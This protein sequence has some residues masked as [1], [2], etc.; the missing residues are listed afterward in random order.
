MPISILIFFEKLRA[1]LCK[2]AANFSAA[3]IYHFFIYGN[4][5]GQKVFQQILLIKPSSVSPYYA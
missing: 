2:S 5:T 4:L 3:K 1:Y